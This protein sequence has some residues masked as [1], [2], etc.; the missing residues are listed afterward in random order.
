MNE[1][2]KRLDEADDASAGNDTEQSGITTGIDLK[3]QILRFIMSG[4][5]AAVVDFGLTWILLNLVETSIFWGKTLG[6]VAGTITAYVI[7]RRWTF[8]AAPSTRRLIAVA[9]LYLITFVTQLGIFQVLLP[10]LYDLDWPASIAQFVAFV[11][12]Q[13]TAT[14]INFIVQRAIIFRVK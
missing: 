13:G 10:M 1:P 9:A 14:V 11:V 3:T 2:S 8:Q 12:A 6:W 7:N 5:L 4:V